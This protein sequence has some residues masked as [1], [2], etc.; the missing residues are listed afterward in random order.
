M[1]F[2]RLIMTTIL[3]N[4]DR[5]AIFVEL[6]NRYRA[7]CAKR[8]ERYSMDFGKLVDEFYPD[9]DLLGGGKFRGRADIMGKIYELLK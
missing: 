2:R 4:T 6:R 9:L 3:N 7:E 8:G 5:A 1:F